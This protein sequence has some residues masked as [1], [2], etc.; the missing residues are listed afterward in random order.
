MDI[1]ISYFL[2]FYTSQFVS[3]PYNGPVKNLVT[4]S[5]ERNESLT[6]SFCLSLEIFGFCPLRPLFTYLSKFLLYLLIINK[7]LLIFD[8]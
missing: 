2:S 1:H 4:F 8:R 3:K 5:R 7:I 6:S